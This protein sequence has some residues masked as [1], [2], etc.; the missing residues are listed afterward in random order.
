MKDPAVHGPA[1]YDGDECMIAIEACPSVARGGC[2]FNIAK[3][4]WRAGAKDQA[5]QDVEKALW[6]AIRFAEHNAYGQEL[7]REEKEM[8]SRC[9]DHGTAALQ[10]S[11]PEGHVAVC[12][13][14]VT[15]QKMLME[16]GSHTFQTK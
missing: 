16:A 7:D 6:Y 11:D 3:Y 5:I 4:L 12:D 13:A 2:L 9:I 14:I 1:H 8:L 15:I 10:A